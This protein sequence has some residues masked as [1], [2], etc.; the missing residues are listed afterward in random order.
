MPRFRY[1]GFEDPERE[2]ARKALW[3]DR[4]DH[5]DDAT[6]FL[7]E[8]RESGTHLGFLFLCGSFD[9][10]IED[11]AERIKLLRHEEMR[12]ADWPIDGEVIAS[13]DDL[14]GPLAIDSPNPLPRL[15]TWAAQRFGRNFDSV[16]EILEAASGTAGLTIL[17]F[18]VQRRRL[19]RCGMK[20]HIASIVD[21]AEQVEFEHG[22]H[23]LVIY[24]IEWVEDGGGTGIELHDA[25]GPYGGW[26][27]SKLRPALRTK[28]HLIKKWDKVGFV[29]F[30]T[31]WTDVRK[32]LAPYLENP[33]TV[34]ELQRLRYELFREPDGVTMEE[35][36]SKLCVFLR[37]AALRSREAKRG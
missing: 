20:R 4:T 29:D 12:Q 35:V 21:A 13:L 17:T 33:E 2:L 24:C 34:D 9:D 31:W 19:Q 18:S 14:G 32:H 37:G 30:D 27:G 1:A 10:A 22:T 7:R 25:R 16:G 3:L 6:Q 15:N 36:L 23:T 5:A 28:S 26:F 11:F 8:L